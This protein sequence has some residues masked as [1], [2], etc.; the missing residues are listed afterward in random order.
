MTRRH[1]A[2]VRK[3]AEP[4]V[5]R[6][7]G[8][9]D[10]HGFAVAHVIARQLLEL[11]R[12]PVAVV[13]RARRSQLEGIAAGRDVRQVQ[14][15]RPANH[16]LHHPEVARLEL[17]RVFLDE[18]EKRRIANEPGLDRF[19]DPA[20]P[21]AIVQRRE[22]AEVVDDGKRRR[23]RA[24]IV[25]LAEGV[26]PVLHADRRVVLRQ[27]RG[28]DAN[29]TDASVR[30]GRRVADDDRAPRRRRSPARTN[31]GRARR[32]ESPAGRHRRAAGRSSTVSPPGTTRTGAARRST[33]W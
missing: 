20:A 9:A 13:E 8:D 6:V 27:H 16:V 2:S 5:R 26:D 25:L 7:Q 21:V 10:R 1:S 23:K 3:P 24:Q 11:V 12:R 28:R 31:A 22:E 19:R 33:S 14:R 30:R 32:P 18:V 15:R 4:G 17:A 29:E